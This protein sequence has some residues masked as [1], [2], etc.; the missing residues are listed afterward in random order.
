MPAIRRNLCPHCQGTGKKPTSDIN[1]SPID[2]LHCSGTGLR[3]VGIVD[4]SDMED[5]LNDILDKCND[6]FEKVN[7]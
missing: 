4:M 6:I 1:P 3:D 2:C 5:K 7:E